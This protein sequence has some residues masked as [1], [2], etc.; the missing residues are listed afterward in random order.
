MKLF[1]KFAAIAFAIFISL[2]AGSY[3]FTA[4]FGGL[5]LF[6]IYQEVVV[7]PRNLAIAVEEVNRKHNTRFTK[8]NCT[9][10]NLKLYIDFDKKMALLTNGK[11]FRVEPLSFFRTWQLHWQT[12]TNK[13]GATSI[14]D[15]HVVF[16]T[17][18]LNEPVIKVTCKS[19]DEGER[20]SAKLGIV[21]QS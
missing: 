21:L 7:K 1:F 19:K 11:S 18:D 16:E 12:R 8:E 20:L 2:T 3:F 5:L 15:V 4:I 9:G 13:Y 17:T 6:V 14:R 10:S